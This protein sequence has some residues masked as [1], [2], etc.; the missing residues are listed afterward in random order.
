M[1]SIWKYNL[2]DMTLTDDLGFKEKVLP[3]GIHMFN[4]KAL[5]LTISHNVSKRLFLPKCQKL[6]LCR[7]G[8][9]ISSNTKANG[10]TEGHNMKQY[11]F[12]SNHHNFS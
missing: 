3:Q 5:S 4:M 2:Y 8:L 1:L 11:A 6:P 9:S 12:F 7:K 10:A